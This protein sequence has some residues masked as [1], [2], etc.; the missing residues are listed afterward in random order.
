MEQTKPKFKFKIGLLI[1]GLF[2]FYTVVGL[3]ARGAL[4]DKSKLFP[5]WSYNSKNPVLNVWTSWDSGFYYDLAQNGYPKIEDG[6]KVAYIP[7]SQNKWL[8]VYAGGG[9]LGENRFALPS[10]SALDKISN[11]IFIIGRPFNDER[12]PIYYG[13]EGIPYC[14]FDGPIDYAR[15]VEVA[16]DALTNPTAC[17]ASACTKSYVTYY[18][19]EAK[20]VVFQE[21]FT[22]DSLDP[23][24]TYGTTRPLGL[25]NNIYMGFGCNTVS[26]KDIETAKSLDYTHQFTNISFGPLYPWLAK[27][28]SAVTGDVVFAG[29]V[30]SLVFYIAS[31]VFFYKLA[32]HFL[33]EKS[34][35][36][37]LLAYLLLPFAFFNY[38]FLPV[39]LFNLLFFAV[40]YFAVV[41]KYAWSIV[42]TPFL[43]LT[44][45]YGFF[46]LAFLWFI[47]FN[48]ETDLAVGRQV[49]EPSPIFSYTLNA[50]TA[51][52]ALC[53]YSATNDVFALITSKM[54]W[55]GGAQSFI[56]GFVAY[57]IQFDASKF[58]E[59]VFFVALLGGL[60]ALYYLKIFENKLLKN[61]ALGCAI[62][63]GLIS[64][65]NGGLTGVLKYYALGFPLVFYYGRLGESNNQLVKLLVVLGPLL[66]AI[67]MTLW[68]ISSRLM[69]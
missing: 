33:A 3:V 48:K 5:T 20:N 52:M 53:I 49:K 29:L 35:F 37:S 6:I 27:G 54:P 4:L 66:G 58:L 36:L 39:A 14:L 67:F 26:T 43:V 31:S 47:Y 59:L 19:A 21:Y 38:A 34:A 18:S 24:P 60:I 64:L 41:K 25:V 22:A 68:T 50:L 69:V 57:F 40:V 32:L 2:V 63:F 12:V 7:A 65:L 62:M 44:S 11:T 8:K 30:L 9:M 46:I 16:K 61:I 10:S 28:L 55:W 1:V 45:F 56:G 42:L 15:D 23:T 51:V 17:G 13:Y